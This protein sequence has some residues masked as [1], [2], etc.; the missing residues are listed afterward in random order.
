MKRDSVHFSR[1]LYIFNERIKQDSQKKLT[2]HLYLS[3]VDRLS[4]L[5]L[6]DQIPA[7]LFVKF[8]INNYRFFVNSIQRAD[9]GGGRISMG[10]SR[11]RGRRWEKIYSKSDAGA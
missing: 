5:V 1:F 8:F 9:S 7:D 11:E 2:D 4:L 6:V 3:R 10:L